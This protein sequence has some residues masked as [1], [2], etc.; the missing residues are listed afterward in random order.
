L[1]SRKKYYEALATPIEQL[2]SS[3]RDA[4]AV[5]HYCT[6]SESEKP[7]NRDFLKQKD[8]FLGAKCQKTQQSQFEQNPGC[9]FRLENLGE[10]TEI[11]FAEY[12]KLAA[13]QEVA[14]AIALYHVGF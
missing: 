5:L 8:D 7:K 3:V 4:I 10:T 12:I 1:V 11:D 14:I 9:L 13:A 6:R 2:L